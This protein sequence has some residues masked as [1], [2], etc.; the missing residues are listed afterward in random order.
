M[1]IKSYILASLIKH[2]QNPVPVLFLWLL[3]EYSS[4][5]LQLLQYLFLPS[6]WVL[7]LPK[8]GFQ[9]HLSLA[10][11]RESGDSSGGGLPVVSQWRGFRTL[12]SIWWVLTPTRGV[13]KISTHLEASRRS[14]KPTSS[15]HSSGCTC[16]IS[17]IY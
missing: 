13:W 16:A 11:S 1:L 8:D 14:Q 2:P 6:Q 17:H 12:S 9:P 7:G 15:G 3:P 5:Y 10:D 4:W